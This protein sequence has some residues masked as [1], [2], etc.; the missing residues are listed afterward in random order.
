[1]CGLAGYVGLDPADGLELLRR[2]VEVQVHRGPD[3]EGVYTTDRS[4]LGHCRLA[5]IDR[6]GG[7]QPMRSADG[8]HAL[9]YNGEVYNYR[10][11]R[12]ELS[13]LGHEFAT[14]SDTE[15][16]LAAWRQWGEEAFDRFNGMF[17]L[18][19]ADAETGEVVLARDQFGIKP[20]HL[21]R[22]DGGC[23]VFASEIRAILASGLVDR[24]P[25]DATIHRYLRFRVH[26]DGERT[27]FAGVT[28]LLPG[29]LAVVSPEGAVERRT[30]TRLYDDLRQLAATR[31][32]YDGTARERVA[33]S[34]R[35]AIRRRL[36]SDVP[37][38]TALSGGLDSSTI[39]GT[40][41][42]LL[43]ESDTEAAAVGERQ[44]AFSAVFPGERNDEERYVDAVAR[45]CGG[46]LGVHKVHPSADAFLADLEDF[47]RAQEEP[48]VSP[49]PYA[50]YRVMREASRHVTVMVDGQGA[51]EMLAG[52][53]PY[54]L[55]HLR[56]LRRRRRWPSLL[57][58]SLRSAEPLW[59]LARPRLLD[60]L[61]HRRP[62]PVDS[63]LAADFLAAHAGDRFEVVADD[64]KAPL[65]DDLF[66]HS[67][68]A[69]LSF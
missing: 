34:L 49:G 53:L 55:V 51:D 44:Q 43:G 56:Q 30:Y 42:R 4:G 37:V 66:R 24:R 52:Y 39:V 45:S 31:Q 17:A 21:A 48:V 16:V 35:T 3:G 46:A 50:Q 5:V 18:A 20:L 60:R 58:E 65:E 13:D 2:M 7:E 32:P 59:R 67:L 1:M 11:L 23:V 22:G 33:A 69:L 47:V 41:D 10:E 40:I 68:P 12:A 19:I 15:V 38:G 62:V 9:V 14:A 25:D 54:H 36:V 29:Q 6:V 64:L 28:R 27:F 8:R 57:T 61:L 63:L 26:D